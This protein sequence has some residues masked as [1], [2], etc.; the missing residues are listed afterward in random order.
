MRLQCLV[1]GGVTPNGPHKLR[2]PILSARVRNSAVAAALV[3]VPETAADLDS[4]AP[5]A[6]HNVWRPRKASNAE[7]V[8]EPT[9]KES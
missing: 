1:V 7:P 3:L 2:F 9:A 5:T 4:E 8:P 6:K